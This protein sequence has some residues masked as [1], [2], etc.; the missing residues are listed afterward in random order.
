MRRAVFKSILFTVMLTT[1]ANAQ[2]IKGRIGTDGANCNIAVEARSGSSVYK[3]INRVTFWGRGKNPNDARRRARDKAIRCVG[4]HYK[5]N[6]F[7]NIVTNQRHWRTM[8]CDYYRGKIDMIFNVTQRVCGRL[9]DGA[10]APTYTYNLLISGQKGCGR[11]RDKSMTYKLG[12]YRIDCSKWRRRFRAPMV[13]GRGRLDYCKY[14]GR[15]CG[16]PAADAFCKSQGYTAA[17]SFRIQH[18]IGS[19]RT[20]TAT[21]G[22]RRLCV[23]RECDGFQEIVCIRAN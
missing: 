10:P 19:N 8:G 5:Q 17:V 18:N 12:D 14:F 4:Y 15:D 13:G 6:T 3:L 20:P 1:A 16:R 23:D 9:R 7:G 22:D 2:V 21:I 11:R